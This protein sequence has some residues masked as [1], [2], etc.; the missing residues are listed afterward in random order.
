MTKESVTWVAEV[1]SS[2]IT[3][4]AFNP[5][6]FKLF[7]NFANGVVFMYDNVSVNTFTEMSLAP[8]VGK[9]F[10]S[11]IK[12]QYESHQLEKTL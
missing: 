12:G 9:F 5:K 6:S 3:K 8:S 1:N 11:D 4:L 2:M 10:H 7:V